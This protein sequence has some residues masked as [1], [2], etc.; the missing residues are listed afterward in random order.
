MTVVR[1][2]VMAPATSRRRTKPRITPFHNQ[3]APKSPS[4]QSVI[5]RIVMRGAVSVPADGRFVKRAFYPVLWDGRSNTLYA[6]ATS[7]TVLDRLQTLFRETF[8]RVLEPLSAGTLAFALAEARG[9]ERAVEDFGPV[10]F[11]GG[12]APATVAWTDGDASSKPDPANHRSPVRA[13]RH[14]QHTVG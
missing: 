1:T 3:F 14:C 8:D 7:A 12:P 2:V 9:Q 4:A 10:P 11:L 13:S 5:P 6:G